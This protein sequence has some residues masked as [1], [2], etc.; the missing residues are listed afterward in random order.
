MIRTLLQYLVQIYTTTHAMDPPG[1]S[2][3]KGFAS[4]SEN[5]DSQRH[6]DITPQYLTVGDGESTYATQLRSMLDHDSG[7]GGSMADDETLS[8]GWMSN[9][10]SSFQASDRL[11]E[12]GPGNS[13]LIWMKE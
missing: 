3:V 1:P 4:E 12:H 10:A 9:S 7:Y 11:G 6:S 5:P 8:R 13:L 2:R